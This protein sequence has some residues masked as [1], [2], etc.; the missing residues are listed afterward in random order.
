MIGFLDTSY[1]VG[2]NDKQVNIKIGV[3]DGSLQRP[4]AVE[5]SI[6]FGRKSVLNV[7]IHST[8]FIFSLV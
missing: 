7:N 4:V 3:I 8:V 6:P 5:L 2:K 1:T